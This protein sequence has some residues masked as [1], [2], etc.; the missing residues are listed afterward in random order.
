MSE[1]GAQD[2]VS[3]LARVIVRAPAATMAGAD[4]AVWHYGAGLTQTELDSQHSELLSSWKKAA[5]R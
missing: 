4:P 3:P 5:R 1:Y 2:M